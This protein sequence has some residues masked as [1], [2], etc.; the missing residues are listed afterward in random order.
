MNDIV[1]G[2]VTVAST[3][4]LASAPLASSGASGGTA[5]EIVA[6]P[7]ER[8]R[9][10]ADFEIRQPSD[11]P[12]SGLRL[13]G[14]VVTVAASG[15]RQVTDVLLKY[16]DD[17]LGWLALEQSRQF[18]RGSRIGIP[19]ELREGRVGDQ[20]AAFFSE[21]VKATAAPGGRITVGHCLWE[22]NGFLF[23]LQGPNLSVEDLARI[24]LSVS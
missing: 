21:V 9:A 12:S 19:F 1:L 7:L 5:D 20:P 11:L 2:T 15:G 6:L 16:A 10:L 23:E 8:A 4:I 17:S 14:V 13:G 22:R 24:A 3:G 18:G